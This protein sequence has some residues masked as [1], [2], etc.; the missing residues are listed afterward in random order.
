MQKL[1]FIEFAQINWQVCWAFTKILFR[2]DHILG[3]MGTCVDSVPHSAY[4]LFPYAGKNHDSFHEK[5]FACGIF[6]YN[7]FLLLRK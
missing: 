7:V 5:E 2:D 6:F 1:Y 4:N 3:S